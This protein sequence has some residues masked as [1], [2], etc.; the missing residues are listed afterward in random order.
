MSIIINITTNS[1][2]HALLYFTITKAPLNVEI[3]MIVKCN[4]QNL[5]FI[6]IPY[7]AYISRVFNFANF[8]NF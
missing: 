7:S 2:R 4:A 6:Y 3:G 1:L 8:A 5:I